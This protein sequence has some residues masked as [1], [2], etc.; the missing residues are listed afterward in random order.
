[1]LGVDGPVT[2]PSAKTLKENVLRLPL[3]H[4][5]LETDSPYLPPQTQR[6]KRNE[7]HHIPL[8]AETIGVIKQTPTEDIGRQT[9]LNAKALFQL[10]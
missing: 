3:D 8:I 5:V 2:Y 7:P 6:G 1:M 10:R 4:L 9:T